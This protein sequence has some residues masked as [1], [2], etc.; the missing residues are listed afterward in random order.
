[1]GE[2]TSKERD[3]GSRTCWPVCRMGDGA[4]K[5]QMQSSS[6]KREMQKA[7]TVQMEDAN[8][9][10]TGKPVHLGRP[11]DRDRSTWIVRGTYCKKHVPVG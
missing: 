1:M 10:E 5:T 11:Y 7:S 8:E 3:R 9:R 4:R 2:W 6:C